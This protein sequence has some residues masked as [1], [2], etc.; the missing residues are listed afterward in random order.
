M[1]LSQDAIAKAEERNEALKKRKMMESQQ[2]NNG[3]E[4]SKLAQPEGASG[5]GTSASSPSA[6]KGKAPAAP[7]PA[8]A[9]N[10]L[11]MEPKFLLDNE[12]IALVLM[13][14]HPTLVALATALDI[15]VDGDTKAVMIGKILRFTGE[16]VSVKEFDIQDG[17]F[18]F[19]GLKK[20]DF[21]QP[22]AQSS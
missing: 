9:A 12:Q 3:T 8:A 20:Q 2:N 11:A 13:M 18:E 1:P 6:G 7:A 19:E 17:N 10:A 14:K 21:Q 16:C 4:L 5:S 22:A 15:Y